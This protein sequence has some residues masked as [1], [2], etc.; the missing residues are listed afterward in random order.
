MNKYFVTL[1]L[2]SQTLFFG[3]ALA[4]DPFAKLTPK[5]HKHANEWAEAVVNKLNDELQLVYLNLFALNTDESIA[6]FM[7]CAEYIESQSEMLPLHEQLGLGIMEIVNKYAES[8]QEKIALK[9]NL[10]K[11][12]K[13]ALWQKLQS[14]I[15]ELIA[16]IS[17]IYYQ[18]LYSNVAKRNRIPMYMFDGNGIIPQEKRTHSLPQPL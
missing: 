6:A 2:L 10:S 9:T 16:H 5:I 14:K 12:D 8:I 13:E 4:A 1:A 18:T 17:N 11:K 3:H 15:Q 7:K